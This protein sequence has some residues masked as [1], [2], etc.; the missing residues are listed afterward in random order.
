MNNY[1]GSVQQM[2]LRANVT[3]KKRVLKYCTL[4]IKTKQTFKG[5]WTHIHLSIMIIDVI[6]V[7]MRTKVKCGIPADTYPTEMG[8]NVKSA[9]NS[10][11][12][13]NKFSKLAVT[14]AH[15]SETARPK[16]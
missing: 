4:L 11:N 6:Q 12:A 10:H 5:I 15:R 7:V 9:S 13:K 16:C 14:K 2:K 3:N 8:S 1:F